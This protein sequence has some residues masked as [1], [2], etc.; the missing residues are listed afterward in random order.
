MDVAVAPQ[1]IAFPTDL[2][3]LNDVCKMSEQLIDLL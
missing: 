1:N 2:N 3:M